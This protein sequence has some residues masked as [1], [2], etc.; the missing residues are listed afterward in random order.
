MVVQ[1]RLNDWLMDGRLPGLSLL[2][3]DGDCGPKTKQAIGALQL[4]YVDVAAPDCRIDPGGKTLEMLF[5]ALAPPVPKVSE[6]SY[7][8]WLN[9]K[10]YV[11]DSGPVDWEKRSSFWAG[12]GAKGSF[13][14]WLNPIDGFDLVLASMY[15]VKS[16]WDNRFIL[17]ANTKRTFS[18]GGGVSAGAVLCFV[19]GIYYPQ[20]LSKIQ[21]AG[22]D[23]NFAMAGKWA[24]FANW[25]VRIP[26][27]TK[28]IPAAK[29]GQYADWD[30]VS[31]FVSV[32][33]GGMTA[34]G[35]SETDTM[36]NFV[37]IDI[38]LGGFGIE[39]DLYYGVSSYKV[40]SAE[41]E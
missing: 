27:L 9:S 7:L 25:A 28:M 22:V 32:L 17:N 35:F 4:R 11:N 15:N 39:V 38:P 13:G 24:A 36:P 34:F 10:A 33:K 16:P 8:D 14:N 2:E 18:L 1:Q 20:D 41:L 26:H 6:V 37:A 31:K 40:I 5:T 30:T 3:A 19:T 29:V 12:V 21:S 23:W